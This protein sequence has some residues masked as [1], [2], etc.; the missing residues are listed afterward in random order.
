[1]TNP[2]PS[3]GLQRLHP[4]SLLFG[5]LGVLRSTLIP[6]IFVT[7]AGPG[8]VAGLFA[9]PIVALSLVGPLLRYLAYRYRLD[10]EEIVIREGI[11]QRNERNIPY[12]RI[13][14]IDLEQNLLHR[15][16][17]VAVVRL[18]TA[19][20]GK[21]EAEIKV[22][23]LEAVERMRR[24]VFARREAGAAVEQGAPQGVEESDEG[25]LV[26]STPPGEL[27][28]AGLI[29]NRGLIVVGI[30]FGALSQMGV[31]D[32]APWER[33]IDRLSRGDASI[34]GI[35]RVPAWSEHPLAIAGIVAALFVGF[36][37][38][39]RALSVV[40]TLAT[41]WGF[42]L[43]RRGD[44][45]RSRYGLFTRLSAT[46]PRH[47]IQLLSTR[48]TPLHR[49]FDRAAV[50]VETAGSVE[51]DGANVTH[52]RWLAPIIRP[53]EIPALLEQALPD[54]VLE[55]L[56]W[57]GLGRRAGGRLIR[58]GL[59]WSLILSL[60][61]A[62][63]LGW[64]ALAVLAAVLVFHAVRARLYVRYTAY[65]LGP[66]AVV[67]RSGWWVRRTSVVRFGKIQAVE[68][69]QSPFDRRYGMAS[70]A[71][72]TAGAGRVGH[73]VAI[74]YLDLGVAVDL[75]RRLED[76]ALRRDFRW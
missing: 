58:R 35:E 27:V 55:G 62:L 34:G 29:S 72:D 71:V 31:W 75:T 10:D 4:I 41:F 44:D 7:F 32:N 47:R 54:V 45:L 25:R 48:R 56:Q 69:A 20:G 18:E 16:F 30:F 57:S 74:P 61:A 49:L 67:F 1:M 76:E 59:L 39:M 36:V 50:Q 3:D 28:L 14:N 8:Y 38:A 64:W 2:T 26:V 65:A 53:A 17:D 11:L 70:V 63:L 23:S 6:L 66:E 68:M 24:L 33:W 5:V 15:L 52:R 19:S 40:W 46:I 21:A 42:E 12:A 43:R 60:P 22:L 9:V 37:V 13:Q 51:T 73:R